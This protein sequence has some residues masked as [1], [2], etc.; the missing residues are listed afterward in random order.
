MPTRDPPRPPEEDGPGRWRA[1]ALVLAAFTTLGLLFSTQIWLDAMYSRAGVSASQALI[2]ALA[3]W[4][5]WALLFPAVY[6]LARRFPLS[7]PLRPRHVA[8]HGLASL[9]LTFGKMAATGAFLGAAGFGPRQVTS[10]INVPLNY[11]TYWAM[12]GAVWGADLRRRERAERL[13][14]AQLEASLAGARLDALAVQLQPHFL[15]NTLNSVAEL[16]HEDTD[17]AERV[18]GRLSTLLRASLD[19]PAGHE[20]PLARELDLLDA[21]ICIERVRF[22]ERL[23]V[24]LLVAPDVGAC[25]VPRFLLQ[26]IVENAVR[27]AVGP[28]RDGGAITIEAERRGDCLM[29]RVGDDGPGLTDADAAR[30]TRS[31]I[32]LA[33]VRARLEALYGDRQTF[34]ILNNPAGGVDVRIEVPF[35]V[36]QSASPAA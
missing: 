32:G 19:A 18:V 13:R 33:N 23:R 7:R 24:R 34:S 9:A 6:W 16:M 10:T 14:A 36:D 29:L 17:A 3:G 22:E 21:Y 26:P 11:V 28:R 31:G 4:Y 35:R 27:H 8:V 30:P 15:F 25:L 1:P 2:L 5:G 12:A 20:V